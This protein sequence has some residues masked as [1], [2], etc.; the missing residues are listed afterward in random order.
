MNRFVLAVVLC[1]LAA[2]AVPAAAQQQ[3]AYT[4][5]SPTPAPHQFTDPAMT[6]NAPA[7]YL[8]APIPPHN[9]TEF[10]QPTIV[11]AFAADYG[12]PNMRTITVQ[13]ENFSGSLNGYESLAETEL[14][15]KVDGIFYKEKKMTTLSNGMPAYWENI[16]VGSGFQEAKRYQYV[17]VDGVRGV[18]L[19]VTAR[20]GEIS[21]DQAKQALANVS[22]VAY[23]RYRY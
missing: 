19:S 11:A 8:K 4:A 3:Q 7:S 17:W 16:T 5:P 22:A 9:P 21:Q 18:I 10:S 6:F 2:V 20:F 23:P 15:D 1:G 12:K 13:M 14:R